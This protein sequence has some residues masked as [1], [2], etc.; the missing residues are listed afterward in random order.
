MIQRIQSVYLLIASIAL[1]LLFI[2]LSIGTSTPTPE[3]MF[4]DGILNTYDNIVL[5]ALNALP[6]IDFLTAIFLFANRKVQMIVTSMGTLL[7]SAVGGI[8]AYLVMNNAA[9]VALGA[10]MPLIA[11]VCGYLAFRSIKKDEETVR[12]A[13]RLR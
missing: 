11:L 9:Q 7:S 12:S 4:S 1:G 13:D 6:A 5:I 10:V 3:G 2:P 8:Y